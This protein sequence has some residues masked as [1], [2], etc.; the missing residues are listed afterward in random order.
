MR[1]KAAAAIFMM[2]LG[3]FHVIF[4]R[5]IVVGR[6]ADGAG[7]CFLKRYAV[8]VCCCYPGRLF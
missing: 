7:L 2:E 4:A 6:T 1:P 3:R 5:G 8:S